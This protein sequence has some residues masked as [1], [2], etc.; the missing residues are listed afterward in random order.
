MLGRDH[1]CIDTRSDIYSLG[2]VLYHVLVNVPPFDDLPIEDLSIDEI[3]NVISQQDPTLPSKRN[4]EFAHIL[5]GDLDAIVVK[6]M[7]RNPEQR[8]QAV[9]ELHD[10]LSRYLRDLPIQANPES[11]WTHL[12]R[13][14]KRN[15]ILIAASLLAILGLLSGFVISLIEGRK[16]IAS[17]S[18]TRGAQDDTPG[19]NED[20]FWTPDG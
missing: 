3:R 15:K 11:R 4:L 16:A 8:Y 6:A 9:S 2:A 18:V 17:C 19:A 12:R 20:L 7:Q 5:R 10:D 14:T 1:G 13:L